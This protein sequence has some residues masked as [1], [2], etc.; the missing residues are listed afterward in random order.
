MNNHNILMYQY[1]IFSV[2]VDI[3]KYHFKKKMYRF[4]YR[5]HT[6]FKEKGGG[7]KRGGREEGEEGK[8]KGRKERRMRRKGEEERKKTTRIKM[9]GLE[10]DLQ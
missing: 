10:T 3:A 8:R 2:F 9:R 4:I 7:G 1:F 5:E 6:P